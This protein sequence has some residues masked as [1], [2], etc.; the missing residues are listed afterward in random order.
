MNTRTENKDII[1]IPFLNRTN[2]G[3]WSLKMRIHLRSRD[4]LDVCKRKLPDNASPSVSNKW[5]KASF[6]AI[7]IISTR[8]TEKVFQEIVN[9][10]TYTNAN[11]L[12]S[13]LIDQ[14]ASKHSV[15]RGRVWMEWQRFIFDG[16]LQ[17]FIDDCRKM[18]MELESV[19]IKVPD[20][21]LSFSLLGKLGGDKDLHQFIDNLTLNEELIEKPELIRTRHQDYANIHKDRIKK[22]PENVEAL[23]TSINEPHKIVYYCKNGKHNYKCTNHQKE[24]CWAEKP[25]LRP[26]KKNKKQRLFNNETHYTEALALNTTTNHLP[27]DKNQ[28]IVGCGA[29]HHMFNN[30]SLFVVKPVPSSMTVTTGD[31]NSKLTVDGIGVVELIF[32]QQKLRLDNCL[33]V[34]KL[35]CNLLSLLELFK[36]KIVITCKDNRFSLEINNKTIING[37]IQNNLLYAHYKLPKCLLTKTTRSNNLWHERLG[38]PGIQVLNLLGLGK[39]NSPCLVC[40]KNKSSKRPFKN[41]FKKT[42]LPLDCIQVDVVGPIVPCCVSGSNYFLTIV[43]Q[44]SGFKIVKFLKRKSDGYEKFLITKREIENK[45]NRKIKKLISDRGGKFVNNQFKELAES[46]GFVHMLAPTETP[47]HNGL[48]ERANRTI[49]A[50][51]RCLLNGSNLSHKYWAEVVNTATYLS[52]LSPTP[53][54]NNNTPYFLWYNTNK[55]LQNL[56]VFGSRAIIHHLRREK[57]WKLDQTGEEG[58]FIGYENDGS[59][60]RILRLKDKKVIITRHAS[61]N[62]NI[63]PEINKENKLWTITIEN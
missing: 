26:I 14:Y 28:L 43:D 21:L 32:N 16:N 42:E 29:T 1:T 56:R 37:Y 38:H 53:S 54:R 45:H 60:Y 52:S 57:K 63:F 50:K 33:Y 46:E 48:A 58:V 27:C 3:H 49:L 36:K 8:V 25:H 11:L 9:E 40:E 31:I 30:M 51:S 61:F 10:E 12:W 59:A 6:E 18:T 17:N 15:N 41:H 5:S 35:K 13:K 47:E 2:F 20:D 44:T 19:N 23:F 24:D 4:L 34:P 7:Y 55:N 22:N 62:K 39:V